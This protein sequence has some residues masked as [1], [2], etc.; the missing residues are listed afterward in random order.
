MGASHLKYSR[1]RMRGNNLS[2]EIFRG[3]NYEALS[4]YE[5]GL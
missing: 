1:S 2:Y 5:T 3:V 4:F